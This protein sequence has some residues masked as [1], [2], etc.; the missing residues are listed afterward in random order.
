MPRYRCFCLTDDD[1]IIAG[2]FIDAEDLPAAVEVAREQW[3]DAVGFDHLEI[4]L[5]RVRL[6]PP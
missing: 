4:W 6:V 5:G 1:R 3:R 2:A